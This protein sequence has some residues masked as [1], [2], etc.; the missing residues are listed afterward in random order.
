MDVRRFDSSDKR[1]FK[2][3]FEPGNAIYEAV[4][5]RY[6]NWNTRTVICCS[7]QSGCPVGCTFCGS[8]GKFI[9]N[10]TD[11]EIIHQIQHILDDQDIEPD[12]VEKFQI[13]FMSM[14]EPLLNRDGVEP[15]IQLLNV[16]YPNAQLLI[17]TVLP[18]V[19][20]H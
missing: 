12:D 14:G 18:D 19:A 9:R 6:P 20:T 3:V 8:G 2:Y 4:A 1:V 7:V 10:L 16:M 15:A 5:Y 17:S 11:K 13:M